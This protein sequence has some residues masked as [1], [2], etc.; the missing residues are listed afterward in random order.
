M[1]RWLL[2]AG[3]QV[4][5]YGEACPIL[6]AISEVRCALQGSYQYKK[7]ARI[8]LRHHTMG[9]MGGQRTIE[10]ALLLKA[11][12]AQMIGFVQDLFRRTSGSPDSEQIRG[13][14]C[15]VLNRLL[16][17]SYIYLDYSNGVL[18]EE[19][20]NIITLLLDHGA[21]P[22]DARDLFL[23]TVSGPAFGASR[24]IVFYPTSP[25]LFA[26]PL[27]YIRDFRRN[28]FI[29]TSRRFFPPPVPYIEDYEWNRFDPT[30]R[31]FN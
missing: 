26:P 9:E 23:T 10:R 4:Y 11:C 20:A 25:P 17:Y 12:E 7:I 29:P 22:I 13:D 31:R 21:I 2:Q 5:V 27:P 19:W 1:V 24:R 3:A 6:L 16:R 28:L 30:I 18:F 14:R 8:L 15:Y